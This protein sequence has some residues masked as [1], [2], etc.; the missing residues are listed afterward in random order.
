LSHYLFTRWRFLAIACGTALVLSIVVSMWM[1][2]QY[3][4]TVSIVIDLPA[5]SDPRAATAISPIYLES[6]RTYEYY[7]E[8]DSLFAAAVERFHLRVKGTES[9]EGL[10]QRILRVAKVKDSKILQIRATLPDPQKAVDVAQFIA[11]GVVKLSHRAGAGIDQGLREVTDRQLSE[12]RA[13]RQRALD[14]YSQFQTRTPVEAVQG[15]VDSLQEVLAK[16]LNDSMSSDAE[17]EDYTAREKASAMGGEQ[18]TSLH[19]EAAAARARASV[20]RRQ[21]AETQSTL[22]AKG[23]ELAKRIAQR[24]QLEQ[25]VDAATTGV[26]AEERH[27][28]ELQ[29]AA[30]GR[31]EALTIVDP[32]ILPQRP[33]SPNLLLNLI[34]AVSSAAILALLYLVFA[35][36]RLD[37]DDR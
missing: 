21:A 28:R 18:L 2:R 25:E 30:G 10:K 34:A 13:R 4:A 37:H 1:T 17:A 3:T 14:A 20:L 9:V 33:S 23:S 6:L 11:D 8:G 29:D 19:E 7:A 16:V 35:F 36:G 15:E 22:T 27:S 12:W 5:G 24:K 26:E 31:G 32:G